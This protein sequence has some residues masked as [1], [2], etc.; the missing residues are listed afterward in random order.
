MTYEELKV[1]RRSPSKSAELS[2]ILLE[3]LDGYDLDT[4]K[5]Q[6]QLAEIIKYAKAEMLAEVQSRLETIIKLKL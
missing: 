2:Y 5:I 1:I 6:N 4:L 3:S